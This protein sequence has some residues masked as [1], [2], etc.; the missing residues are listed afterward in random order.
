MRDW[1][2]VTTGGL[3]PVVTIIRW[4]AP[5]TLRFGIIAIG[6]VND[7]QRKRNGRK[8]PEA[9]VKSVLTRMYVSPVLMMEGIHGAMKRLIVIGPT[10]TI[11]TVMFMVS[12]SVRQ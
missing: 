6:L 5:R 11:A 3:R 12:A 7:F 8:L 1:K 10:I 4:F 9:D 2:R